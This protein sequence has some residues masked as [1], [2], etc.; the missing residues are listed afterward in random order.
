MPCS[1]CFSLAWSEAQ[2]KKNQEKNPV[3]E[4]EEQEVNPYY[5]FA[6]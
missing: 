2:L 4:E 6:N 1:G 3:L 5:I